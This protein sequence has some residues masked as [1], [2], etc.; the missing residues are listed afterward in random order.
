MMTS[1]RFRSVSLCQRYSASWPKPSFTAWNASSS[2]LLPGNTTMP[3]RIS[4]PYPLRHYP[5]DNPTCPTRLTC[6]TSVDLDSVA[7]DDR[8]GQHLVGHFGG[9]LPRGARFVRF[10]IQL[11]ILSL[12]HVADVR[13]AER[14]ERLG[15]GPPLRIEHRRLQRHEHASAHAF[16]PSPGGTPGRRCGRRAS[17][18]RPDRRRVRCPR[19]SAPA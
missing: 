19:L 2:Q 11:E 5:D 18:A 4:A 15:D 7:L 6:P 14:V 8:I 3:N 16:R 17:A 13:I 10:Q 12:P 9:E 1:A